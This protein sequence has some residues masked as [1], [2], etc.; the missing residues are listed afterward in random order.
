M[1][2][3]LNCGEVYYITWTRQQQAQSQLQS[4]NLSAG[5]AQSPP[6][7]A[8]QQQ[9]QSWSRVY[10][11]TG[12]NDSAP[13]KPIGDLIKRATF[14]MP[15][16]SSS[17][18]QA[19]SNDQLA[20]NA[21]DNNYASSPDSSSP[22]APT[23]HGGSGARAG[24]PLARLIIDEPRI[25][26]E[27]LYKC[28]VTYVRGK[29]PSISLVKLEVLALPKK[30]QIY[31]LNASS[32]T[33]SSASIVNSALHQ[34]RH[35]LA[36]GQT[37][38]N[39][40]E[41]QQLSLLCLVS[42]G[43]PEP[44]SVI[45]R[46]ID[47]SG[48]TINLV[49]STIVRSLN[50]AGAVEVELNHTLTSADLGAKFECHLEH[51]AL[52]QQQSSFVLNS[53]QQ[54][55][56]IM[57]ASSSS[58]S[59][60]SSPSNRM[61]TTSTH[62]ADADS[63]LDLHPALVKNNQV[64]QVAPP[65]GELGDEN[66][67]SS[68]SSGNSELLLGAAGDSLAAAS[69]SR[70]TKSLDSHVFVDLNG[71]LLVYFCSFFSFVRFFCFAAQVKARERKK[72][73]KRKRRSANLYATFFLSLCLHLCHLKTQKTPPFLQKTTTVG[74]ASLDLFMAKVNKRERNSSDQLKEGDFVE[75]ECVAYNSKP[76][77]NITWFNGLEPIEQLDSSATLSSSSSPQSPSSP[78]SS[79]SSSKLT[80][81]RATRY[82]R[83]LQRNQVQHNS[84]GQTFTTHSFLSIKLSRHEHRAQ[85][86]CHAHN[87]PM[88]K[89]IVKSLELQVHCK[90]DF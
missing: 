65:S 72:R 42:G 59:S 31:L 12:A 69:V 24:K 57:S 4:V 71:K 66:G 68:S 3:Q 47:S 75:L 1:V 14:I 77:A 32:S 50:G 22:L 58:S 78:S 16:S 20:P 41:Q 38:G 49:G 48:R 23:T 43:R 74:V 54:P 88:I 19:A 9:Q 55:D 40:E 62:D 85:I 13:H 18:S 39:L 81:Q 35:L 28:D 17:S 87:A 60:S 64:A 15:H 63:M 56:I 6:A 26:D 8:H 82:K 89:P 30:A 36:D 34:K 73:D 44:K 37:I 61:L 10:L 46:K 90:C 67:S 27:A 86:S 83:L 25:S 7:S 84:D 79:S 2:D 11:Y 51:E 80:T 52:E 5:S 70:S 76:P 21:D 33:A 29:C 45:W 53:N